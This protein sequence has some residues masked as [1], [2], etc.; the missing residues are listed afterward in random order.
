MK[1]FINYLAIFFSL[2][3]SFY[4]FADVT[5]KSDVVYGH[6]DGLALIYDVIKPDNANDA[7]IVFMMLSLIHI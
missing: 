5:I 7:A 4:S 2:T 6:K 1:K 3:I